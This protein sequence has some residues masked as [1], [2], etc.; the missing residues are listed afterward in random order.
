M[1][2]CLNMVQTWKYP[3]LHVD[4]YPI[5]RNSLYHSSILSLPMNV[6]TFLSSKL[7]RKYQHV[8]TF[9][10]IIVIQNVDEGSS[11]PNRWWILKLKLMFSPDHRSNIAKYYSTF[12][13]SSISLSISDILKEH[14]LQKLYSG[15]KW[16]SI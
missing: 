10:W 12:T 16:S 6:V 14:K 15:R 7:A 8:W 3:R 13:F 9:I 4:M 5:S 2:T 1:R 11:I